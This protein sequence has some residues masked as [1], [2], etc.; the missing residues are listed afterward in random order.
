MPNHENDRSADVVV[1]GHICLDIIPQIRADDFQFV[2][3]GLLETGPAVLATGGAVANTGLALH[4]LGVN[5]R[6]VGKIGDDV[7]GG[8]LRDLVSGDTL[9]L[10][11]NMV[12]A[13]GEHTSYSVILSPENRDRMFLHCPGCN[14]TFQAA[15]V[16]DEVLASSRLFHFGYPPLLPRM[17]ANGGEELSALMR[18]AKSL[19]V[20]TSL[21]LS[22][23]DPNGPS[24]AV[25]WPAI[26]AAVLPYVDVFLPSA[27]EI[28]WMLD[29]AAYERISSGGG[30][31]P[32]HVGA[33]DLRHISQVLL[34]MGCAVAGVKL[35]ERGLYLRTAS[36]ARFGDAGRAFLNPMASWF[37][38]E[39]WSP[40]FDVHVVGATGAGDA[41]IAGFLMA[42]LRGDD[43]AQCLVAA[44]AVGACSVEAVDAFSGV[45]SWPET[46]AR[47]AQGWKRC[48]THSGDGWVWDK[49]RGVFEPQA[50]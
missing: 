36:S 37:D 15:D 20:T 6:L 24:S 39:F 42:L 3:G 4:Q 29:R 2:P 23:P 35:G 33:L 18:R 8:A 31:F 9:D 7:L 16:S 11:A 32:A 19:G 14:A 30:E 40:C 5:V 12:V 50:G 21:D 49:T 26:L 43:P 13:H 22:M 44:C 45:R 38:R 17:Y 41:T 1:A 48:A 47:L 10:A 46:S 27:E 25:D 28:F 34:D